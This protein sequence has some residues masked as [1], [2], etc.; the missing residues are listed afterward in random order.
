M[1]AAS[2]AKDLSFLTACAAKNPYL[3]AIP[4]GMKTPREE[5]PEMVELKIIV[6][7]RSNGCRGV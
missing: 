2:R 4:N 5:K 7:K 1:D 3:L 6:F